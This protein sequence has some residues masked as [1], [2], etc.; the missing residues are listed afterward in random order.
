MDIA[1]LAAVPHLADPP[2]NGLP[3]VELFEAGLSSSRLWVQDVTGRRW[4]LPIS[5]WTSDQL[6]GDAELLARC[7]GATL[8]IGCGPGRL[9][10]ALAAAGRPALGID[11]SAAAIALA[12]ASGASAL[13]RSVF[14]PVPSRGLWQCA[15]LADGNIG[16]GGD[17]LALLG[18][19]RELLLPD[20]CVLV[21][22]AAP[23]APTVQSEIRLVDDEGRASEWF[24]WAYVGID[25]I[26]ALASAAG[27][28]ESEYWESCGRWFAQLSAR[29][30]S[31][32]TA[33]ST[34]AASVA[35]RSV[36]RSASSGPSA[37]T[38]SAS[39][40]R[41]RPSSSSTSTPSW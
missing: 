41:T 23:G 39:A 15:L 18:R 31:R 24:P 7:L 36:K 10:A 2:R 28:A 4:A 29:T 9:V 37:R 26:D 14:G 5:D 22:L 8:D 30:S 11:V 17:P 27:F 34:S 1:D 16:I 20:G 33:A 32:K 13:R 12:C 6:P 40:W 25:G 19:A 35:A 3:A 38:T 21:E